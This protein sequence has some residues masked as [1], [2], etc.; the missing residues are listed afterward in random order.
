[1]HHFS[2]RTEYTQKDS[3]SDYKLK[4]IRLKVGLLVQIV[5]MNYHRT[6]FDAVTLKGKVYVVGGVGLNGQR[7][8]HGEYYDPVANEWHGLPGEMAR[9][10]SGCKLEVLEGSLYCVGGGDGTSSL[11]TV[12]RYDEREGKWE[13]VSTLLTHA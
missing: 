13:E 6:S 9:A 11:A 2:G 4:I 7:H 1:M 10:R 5:P 8:K 12:E 3:G